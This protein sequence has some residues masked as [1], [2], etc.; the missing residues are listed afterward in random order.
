MESIL[1]SNISIH[2]GCSSSLFSRMSSSSTIFSRISTISGE[3]YL[4]SCILSRYLNCCLDIIFVPTFIY[5]LLLILIQG[6]PYLTRSIGEIGEVV[7]SAPRLK[8]G[9]AVHGGQ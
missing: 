8:A 3:E 5:F 1:F 7:N 4:P 6:T 9:Q 2:P